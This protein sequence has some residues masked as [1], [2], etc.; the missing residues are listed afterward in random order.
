MIFKQSSKETIEDNVIFI[1]DIDSSNLYQFLFVSCTL[2]MRNPIWPLVEL[3]NSKRCIGQLA[4]ILK[5]ITH[6]KYFV[7]NI[8]K[9]PHLVLREG[10]T[11]GLSTIKVF[12][13]NLQDSEK[14]EF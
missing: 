3:H 10:V 8:T 4:T 2:Q 1:V 11:V 14:N 5:S 13:I 9:L 7:K 12:F 6:H